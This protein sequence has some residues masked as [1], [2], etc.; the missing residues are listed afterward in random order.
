LPRGLLDDVE[1]AATVGAERRGLGRIVAPDDEAV[2]GGP[3]EREAVV[4]RGEV[5]G[6]AEPLG[7]LTAGVAAAEHR[8]LGTGR[9]GRSVQRGL[10]GW[11]AAVREVE[12]EEWREGVERG[13]EEGLLAEKRVRGFG[14]DGEAGGDAVAHQVAA[15][16]VGAGAGIVEFAGDKRERRVGPVEMVARRRER[17]GAGNRGLRAAE[18]RRVVR[19]VGADA[20]R[21]DALSFEIGLCA[22][23]DASLHAAGEGGVAP[24]AFERRDAAGG[25]EEGGEVTAG[26]VAG[27]ADGVGID[28]VGGGIGAE[29][30][31]GGLGVVERGGKLRLTGEAVTDGDGDEAAR[32]ERLGE[33]PHAGAV[34]AGPAAAVDADDGRERPGTRA[35]AEEIEL[36]LALAVTRVGQAGMRLESRD[37]FRGEHGFLR[38]GLFLRLR[39]A[40]KCRREQGRDD[41][42]GAKHGNQNVPFTP[43]V[44]SE[45]KL[46]R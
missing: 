23:G 43:M 1:A 19:V 27:D 33:W 39:L 13:I 11:A 40:E 10:D 36:Q 38:R 29:P 18:E 9:E 15:D 34:A 25:G 26:G 22:A 14:H 16:V 30:A 44:Q 12:R 31:D 4:V 20:E 6:L 7:A 41:Q 46:S 32:G 35:W 37:E 28:A 24:V 2:F 17:V 21:G 8:P 42:A 3:L 5:E 45:P